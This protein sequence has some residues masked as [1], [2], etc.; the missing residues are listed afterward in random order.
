MTDSLD[1]SSQYNT[2]LSKT[3]EAKFQE[4]AKANN[5]LNDVY[6]Y[7]IRGAWKAMQ[8][9]KMSPDERG[10]LGDLYKKPN[11][12]TFSDQSIYHGV[13]NNIGGSWADNGQGGYVFKASPTSMWKP[14]QLQQYFKQYEPDALLVLPQIEQQQVVNPAYSDPFGFTIK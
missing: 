4:W 3:D 2:K 10:H 14:E 8:S 13:D 12:P 7:D 1:F 6:D 5:K 9:G 11:H